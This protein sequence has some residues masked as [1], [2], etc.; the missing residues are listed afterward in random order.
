MGGA[1][2]P[3]CDIRAMPLIESIPAGTPAPVP[4]R[5]SGRAPAWWFGAVAA[6]AVLLGYVLIA[7]LLMST[8]ATAAGARFDLW[9]VLA[10][11][12]PGWLAAH[13]VPLTIAGAPLSVLPFMPTLVLGG[14]VVRL[15]AEVVRRTERAGDAVWLVV[16]VGT[17]HA[18]AGG[19]A[20][21]QLG[22]LVQVSV[23][24]AALRCGFVAAAAAA[25]GAARQ[26]G[27]RELL[28]ARLDPVL[29]AGV[30]GGLVAW[31]PIAAAGALVVSAALCLS[32]SRVAEAFG[33]ASVGDGFGLA[34]LSL[35]YL[36]NALLAGWSFAAGPGFAIGTTAVGPL[37]S[38]PGA[39]PEIP[40]LAVLPQHAP[41][42]WWALALLLPVG[43]GAVVGRVCGAEL[44]RLAERLRAAATA[45]LIVASGVLV[46]GL[47]TGGRAGFEPATVHPVVLALLTF[48]WVF[49]P[50]A[51]VVWSSSSA[52]DDVPASLDAEDLDEA[53]DEEVADDLVEPV[54]ELGELEPVDEP[55]ADE[56]GEDEFAEEPDDEA[57]RDFADDELTP[58]DAEWADLVLRVQQAEAPEEPDRRQS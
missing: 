52:E 46:L 55:G 45:A 13:Q 21:A 44:G 57:D 5:A 22:G 4:E 33:Q 2:R 24:G 18:L 38:S 30:R 56:T 10:A 19:L 37:W 50:A 41:A 35:M 43:A 23:P 25:L 58:D 53:A 27:F 11:A 9:V 32:A 49:A 34:L 8:V 20:A 12:V 26:R 16:V 54:D 40:L 29:R 39:V 47:A 7:V 17:G 15:S 36:P 1:P 14:L 31:A 6:A 3:R 48:G 42:W 28:G 51:V